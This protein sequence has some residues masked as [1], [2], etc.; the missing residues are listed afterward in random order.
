MNFESLEA[1]CPSSAGR[2]RALLAMAGWAGGNAVH[3]GDTSAAHAVPI[4]TQ[5]PAVLDDMDAQELD[6]AF[7]MLK[8]APNLP[9][10]V[11]RFAL[12]SEA[13]R[14]RLGPPRRLAYGPTD[15]EAMD[16]YMTSAPAA[17]VQVLV[18]GGAFNRGS[19][20]D[21]A[22]AAEL[23]VMAGA[24][25]AVLDFAR[26]QDVDWRIEVQA[27]QVRRALLWVQR[28]ARDFGG[29]PDRIFVS[30]HSSGA[31]L[32]AMAL[33]TDWRAEFG[34]SPDVVKG[35]LC[36]SATYDLRA[37]RRSAAGRQFAFTDAT[38]HALS[39]MRHVD[40]IQAP[41]IVAVGS[42]ETDLFKRQSMAFAEALRGAGKPAQLLLAEGYNHFEIIET[43][44]NPYGLLGR[45]A[46]AH[47][48]LGRP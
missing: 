32:A 29:D 36:C 17:P 45:A 18:H 14:R 48:G 4:R 15:V 46:L 1:R 16:L 6:D 47:V 9:Q 28:H 3:A 23:F 25:L 43:L 2:R 13:V 20:R 24:H 5:G 12:N 27:D 40:H 38:E 44:A 26:A 35:G 22:F 37:F 7:D 30:G 31:E 39:A 41:L 8:A 11:R 19:A 10:L 21:F 34:A 33:S 42:L